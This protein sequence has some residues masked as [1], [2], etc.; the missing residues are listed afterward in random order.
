MRSSDQLADGEVRAIRDL[1]SSVGAEQ[2]ARDYATTVEVVQ[3]VIDGRF[4]AEVQIPVRAIRG[5]LAW[6]LES[7][8]TGRAAD[9]AWSARR[10]GFDF[11]V[12]LRD[13]SWFIESGRLVFGGRPTR[14]EAMDAALPT[15]IEYAAQWITDTRNDL[16]NGR[17]AIGARV[18]DGPE[19]TS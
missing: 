14:D 5:G 9:A 16:A 12:A 13:G 7:P 1:A 19:A 8:V 3:G 4:R 15:F 2:L 10:F 18:G 17:V 6:F 11:R